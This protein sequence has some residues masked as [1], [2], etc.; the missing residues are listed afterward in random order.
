MVFLEQINEWYFIEGMSGVLKFNLNIISGLLHIKFGIVSALLY[1]VV[2]NNV[3]FIKISV[4][5]SYM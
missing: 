2:S 1:N 5:S 4:C 3:W